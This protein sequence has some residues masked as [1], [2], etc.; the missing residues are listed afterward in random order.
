MT[1]AD[2]CCWIFGGF[3]GFGGG[4]G[5]PGRSK[6]RALVRPVCT[7]APALPMIHRQ[8]LQNLGIM[9]RVQG[10]SARFG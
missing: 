2:P 1:R 5:R 9:G 7:R 3:E 6:Q 10:E 4:G 8:M